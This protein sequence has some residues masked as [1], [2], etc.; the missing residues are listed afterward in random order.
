VIEL[1]VH[2]DGTACSVYGEELD[3]A[4]LGEVQIRRASMVEPDIHGQWWAD[5][6]PVDGPKLGPF[7]LRSLALEAE[8]IWLRLHLQCLQSNSIG[9]P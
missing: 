8:V 1:I 2:P 4:K 9:E 3:L 5:L 7:S 6:S